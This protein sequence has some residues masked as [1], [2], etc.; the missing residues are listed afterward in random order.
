VKQFCNVILVDEEIGLRHVG[1]R[2]EEVY[3]G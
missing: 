2:A 3:C 1:E